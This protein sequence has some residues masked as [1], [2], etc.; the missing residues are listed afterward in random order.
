MPGNRRRMT[1][2]SRTE[3]VFQILETVNDHG[4]EEDGVTQTTIRYEVFLSGAQLKEYLIALTIHG[5]LS[6]N[7]TSH[8]YKTTQ[9]GLK[10]LNI[11]YKVD[12][13]IDQGQQ[14]QQLQSLSSPT[15]REHQSWMKSEGGEMDL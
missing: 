14:R 7:S 12:D 11:C 13:M 5:L 9:K 8:R 10:F 3:V 1:N 2:R 6:Y 15:K 4:E